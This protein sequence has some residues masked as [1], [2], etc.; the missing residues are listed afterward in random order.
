MCMP[1]SVPFCDI[2]GFIGF[3]ISDDDT[4]PFPVHILLGSTFF[5]ARC[6]SA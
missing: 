4:F 6:T 3:Y 2:H 1:N 5:T